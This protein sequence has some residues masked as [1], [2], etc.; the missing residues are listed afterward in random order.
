MTDYT[1]PG[2]GDN[3]QTD[4]AGEESARLR[5]DYEFVEQHVLL[6]LDAAKAFLAVAD[7]A[8]K[9]Q[10]MFLIKQLRDQKKKVL[11]FHE[12]EKLP[13]MRR[14]QAV[15]QYFFRLSDM[16]EKRTKTARDG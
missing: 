12:L 8:T 10:C 2:P 16:L 1:T 9:S 14:S 4:P 6:I 11:G 15:D 3:I 7:D 5:R 13:H